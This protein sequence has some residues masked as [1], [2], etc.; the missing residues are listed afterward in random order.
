MIVIPSS[1][2]VAERTTITALAARHRLP[3]VYG[4]DTFISAGG[5]LS[6]ATDTDDLARHIAQ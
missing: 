3:A 5:L 6:Y 2:T 1:L 4:L